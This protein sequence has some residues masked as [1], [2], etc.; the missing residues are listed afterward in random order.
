MP[1]KFLGGAAP[2][3]AGK[4]RREVLAEWLDLAGEPLLRHQ[5]RQPRLGPLLRPGHRRAGRRRPRQQSAQQSGTARR[6]W[7][8]S[9]SST[10][11]TSS[12]WSATSAT[13]RPTSASTQ[14]NES[15]AT[16]DRNFAHANVRRIPAENAARL[17]QPGDRDARTS[18]RAC[19]WAPGRCRSP[20]ATPAT[21]FLTT[22]GRAPRETVCACEVQDRS[23]P[24]AGAAPAQ[25]R[26]GRKARSSQGGV[27]KK[28]L[29]DRQDARSRSSKRSTSAA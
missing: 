16:D 27:I 28:L 14:R 18:S 7:A 9:S 26:H 22:F 10:S 12:S 23:D 25:R 29:D 2:D 5:R 15:N 19:R 11:T 1:P 4:D 3:V 20:T 21:Y 17:H 24:V 13:R 6:R 8:R